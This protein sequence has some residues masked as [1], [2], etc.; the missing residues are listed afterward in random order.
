MI[1]R[2]PTQMAHCLAIGLLLTSPLQATD[3]PQPLPTESA[4]SPAEQLFVRRIRPLLAG[5]CGACH[6]KTPI[7]DQMKHTL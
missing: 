6:G 7:L 1:D 2:L 4:A 5:R 3:L